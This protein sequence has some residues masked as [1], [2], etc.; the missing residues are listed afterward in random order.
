METILKF[1]QIIKNK[2]IRVTIRKS[3]GKDILAACGQ[4][5][6]CIDFKTSLSSSPS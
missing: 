3:K 1:A 2:G 4:L 5:K 6:S